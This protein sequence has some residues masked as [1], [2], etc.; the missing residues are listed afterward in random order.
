MTTLESP[1]IAQHLKHVSPSSLNRFVR[2]PENFRRRYICHERDVAGPKALQGTADSVAY[3]DFYR[4]SM[5]GVQTPLSVLED[6]Y[7]DNDP[8]EG[9]RV[10]TWKTRRSTPSST[11]ASPAFARTTP[12]RRRCRRRS[13]WRRR[14]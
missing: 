11:R 7:R 1:A 3:A 5:G 10:T 4:A 2:C 14:C 6:V 9:R 8:P 13:Q 12:W